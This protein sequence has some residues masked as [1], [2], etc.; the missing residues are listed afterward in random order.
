MTTK[1][2]L[3][4]EDNH[5][6]EML[7]LRALKK[8]NL[9]NRVDVARDGQQAIDYLFVRASLPREGT[10]RRRWFFWTSICRE[11]AGLKCWSVYAPIYARVC[12]LSSFSPPQMRSVTDYAVITT[13]PI[14]LLESPWTS[15]SSLKPYLGWA[16]TGW[17]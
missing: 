7:T 2:I 6:D 4:V 5:Q 8:I 10:D 3:L 1:T 17:Q 13:A 15:P 14:A 16:S 11:S 12:C 9:A